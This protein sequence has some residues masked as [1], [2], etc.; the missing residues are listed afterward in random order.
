MSVKSWVKD[1][2]DKAEE[3]LK[4]F[5][6]KANKFVDEH[7]R[8]I[9]TGIIGLFVGVPVVL[10]IIAPPS[11]TSE[12]SGNKEED[13]STFDQIWNF[14]NNVELAPGE[15]YDIQIGDTG[16][17][18]ITHHYMTVVEADDSDVVFEDDGIKTIDVDVA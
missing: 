2:C 13:Q 7:P 4:N 10:G 5:G 11:S 6:A 18:S 15:S 16:N 14:V 9:T 1:K 8:L 3:G 12:N 17:T